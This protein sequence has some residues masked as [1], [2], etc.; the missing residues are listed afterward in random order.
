MH[1]PTPAQLLQVWEREGDPSA[2]ACGLLLLGSSCDECSVEALAALPLGQRDALLLQLRERLFGR[3]ICSVAN[4]PQCAAAVEATF[5]CDDLLLTRDVSMTAAPAPEHVLA[6]HGI[7]VQ[8]RLPDSN[9]LLAL[10]AC[11]DTAAARRLLFERC[12]LAAETASQPHGVRGLPDELQAQIAQAM[13]QADPQADLQLA[14]C[15]PD[16]GHAWQPTF[17]IARF[18]WQELHAWALRMLRD[19]DTLAH[20]YHWHEADIL[21]LSPRRRQAYLELCAP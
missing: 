3:E 15:C 1:T 7:R 4:C 17:D 10:E 14:F 2:A 20:S 21:A 9:D 6:A 8:F 19:V 12:V 13:A 16:C 5:R 11:I 18:L